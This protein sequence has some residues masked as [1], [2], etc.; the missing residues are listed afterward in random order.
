MQVHQLTAT[1][2][3][4]CRVYRHLYGFVYYRGL[5]ISSPLK[6][7]SVLIIII[8]IRNLLKS[9]SFYN[10]VLRG[11]WLYALSVALD[12][13]SFTLRLLY[14]RG[15]SPLCAYILNGRVSGHEN[16]CGILEKMGYRDCAWN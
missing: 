2:V 7:N 6:F 1:P 15:K 8:R 3:S 16:K 10:A 4:K 5:L 14:P 12:G 9:K 13:L 11:V